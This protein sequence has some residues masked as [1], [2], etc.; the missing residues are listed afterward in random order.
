MNFIRD[1]RV[2]AAFLMVWCLAISG[3]DD[4]PAV[5]CTLEHLIQYVQGVKRAYQEAEAKLPSEIEKGVQLRD[6]IQI[7]SRIDLLVAAVVTINPESRVKVIRGPAEVQYRF[8]WPTPVL[9]KVINEGGVTARLHVQ[10]SGDPLTKACLYEEVSPAGQKT[11]FTNKLSGKPVEYQVMLIQSTATGRR[12]I[13]LTFDVGQATQDLGFRAEL[14]ILMKPDT[15][16][17]LYPFIPN[18]Q[19]LKWITE[20]KDELTS[21]KGE[22]GRIIKKQYIQTNVEAVAGWVGHH[23]KADLKIQN[24]S[25][26]PLEKVT[27]RSITYLTADGDRVPAY[28]FIPRNRSGKLPA[29]LCLHQTTKIGKA[30]PAGV[31]GLKNLHYAL[32]LAERGYVTIAPDYP[33]YGDY[34]K[35]DPYEIFH[36]KLHEPG[37]FQ[38]PARHFPARLINDNSYKSKYVSATAKGIINH[39]TAIDVLETLPEVDTGRIGC[40]GHSLGG[41]NTLFVSLFDDRIKVLAS[42]CGFCSFPKYYGGNLKGWSHQ[43]Y[44]PRIANVYQCDPA[45]MPFDFTEILG[46]MAPRPMFINA[47]LKDSNFE[48][49]GVKDCVRAALPVYRLSGKPEH[50]VVEHPDCGHDFPAEVRE[51]CYAFFDRYLRENK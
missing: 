3:A 34:L 14:P 36:T 29:I 33:G 47:P 9:I 50:L 45:R 11:P 38:A 43:G 18:K 30:E 16:N 37:L 39:R 17:E 27:R 4:V 21:I 10:C 23:L 8:G 40:I 19:D 42:S 13:K 41:H 1:R 35:C 20:D 46:A 32:E 44:M 6:A 28:L 31:G 48:V 49:E 25:E 7:Q 51:R 22:V 24:L 15:G 12:E 5:E 2:M 26:Q